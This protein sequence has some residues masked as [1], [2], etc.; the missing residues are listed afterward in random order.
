[1]SLDMDISVPCGL[2]INELL[3]NALKHAFPQGRSGRVRLGLHRAGADTLVLSVSDNG[4]GFPPGIDVRE[5][6]T[7]GLRIVNILA[8]QIRATLE[9]VPG[10]GTT[11]TL[12]FPC[13]LSG[14]PTPAPAP[15]GT[16]RRRSHPRRA[17][18][19]TWLPSWDHD[20]GERAAL[21]RRDDLHQPV[22]REAL[23]RRAGGLHQA[24]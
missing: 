14:A 8:A 2:I 10:E 21:L 16:R 22:G 1:M 5:P 24:V 18:W 12:S 7:L 6:R 20:L 15:R 3:S 9:L 23:P 4:V 13:A 17:S 19:T 11:I